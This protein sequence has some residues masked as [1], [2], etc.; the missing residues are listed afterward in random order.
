MSQAAPLTASPAASGT[1][2]FGGMFGAAASDSSGLFSMLLSLFGQNAGGEKTPADASALTGLL[3][4]TGTPQFPLQLFQQIESPEQTGEIIAPTTD[5]TLPGEVDL[6][7]L[8]QSMTQAPSA[9][10][11]LK[12]LLG[13]NA[14]LDLEDLK[15][16]F[17]ALEKDRQQSLLGEIAALLVPPSA[18]PAQP[19]VLLQTAEASGSAPEILTAEPAAPAPQIAL[20]VTPSTDSRSQQL[21][22]AGEKSRQ[23]TLTAVNQALQSASAR[24][25]LTNA[26]EDSRQQANQTKQNV[27]AG[28]AADKASLALSEMSAV[29]AA[30]QAPRKATSSRQGDDDASSTSSAPTAPVVSAANPGTVVQTGNQTRK[31]AHD[32]AAIQSPTTSERAADGLRAAAD[33]L[34]DPSTN[35]NGTEAQRNAKGTSFSEHLSKATLASHSSAH[36]PVSEQVAVQMSHALKNGQ[37]QMTIKL[38]PAELGRIEVRI[39]VD[40]DGRVTASFSVDQPAT[41]DLLQ[42]DQRG[43]E[44]SLSDVGLRTDAGTLSFNLRN[45]NSGGG[46]QQQANNDNTQQGGSNGNRSSFNPDGSL[47]EDTAPA[48]LIEMVWHLSPDRV[49]V[50]I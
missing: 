3:A 4:P 38:K 15:S 19:D 23:D 34:S 32:I 24:E 33:Q 49:D 25:A 21:D 8:F 48:G 46:Q 9:S 17:A 20:P 1:G 16:R 31:A 47:V 13:D 18:L 26:Q 41:L 39:N 6:L 12:A 5:P 36:V 50:R 45:D 27:E 7:A 42:R 11:E 30:P 22:A 37:N 43:L 2:L 10:A 28:Q 44:R 14:A 35:L 29:T 40:N